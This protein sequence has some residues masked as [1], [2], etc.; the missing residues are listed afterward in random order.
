VTTDATQQRELEP[1][2][3]PT[4]LRTWLRSSP[5]RPVA[6]A[7]GVLLLGQLVVRGLLA[8]RGSF[9]VDDLAFTGRAANL[10][11]LSRD[12][13]LH[14]YNSHLMPGAFVWV[15]LLTHAWPLQFGPVATVDIALQLLVGIVFYRLL[16]ELFGTR[17]A[18]LVPFAIYLWSPIT[19]PAF[20][21]WAAALNQLPQQLA[22]CLALLYHAR[23]LRFGRVRT[24]VLG[25]VAVAG[26]LLFSEKT[27]LVVPLIVL[28]TALYFCRGGPWRRIVDTWRS[29]VRV[30]IAYLIVVVPYA[31]YYVMEVPSPARSGGTGGDMMHLVGSSYGHAVFP[32]LL[33]GPWRWSLIGFAGGLAHPTKIATYLSALTVLVIVVGSCVFIRGAILGWSLAVVYSALNLTLL[34]ASR[35]TMVGPIIGDEFRYVTDVALVA[36]L[37]GALAVLPLAGQWH[38]RTPFRPTLRLHAAEG[39]ARVS[40]P[41]LREVLPVRRL[42]W[43]SALLACAFVI[44]ALI[45]TVKYDKY[46][47][48]NPTRPYL[49]HL[50]HDLSALPHGAVMYDGVVPN[51]VAWA[52]LAPYNRYSLLLKPLPNEPAFLEPGASTP[53]L[54]T[55]DTQGY[56][57]L[58]GVEGIQITKGPVR[59]CGWLLGRKATS[60]PLQQRTF[61]WT[62]VLRMGYIASADTSVRI[63]TGDTTVTV[64]IQSGLHAAY[65]LVTGAVDTVSVSGTTGAATICTNDI[66]VGTPVPLPGTG[67]S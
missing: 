40:W 19:L 6:A 43:L 17:P 56:V 8:Y 28:F 53:T 20:L 31:T 10:P 33:G 9:F 66:V 50:R 51:E 18:I 58:A 30:W 54:Y 13:L 36:A 3:A 67:P 2:A 45:S 48:S 34:A 16:R 52:L 59:N 22:M 21:W 25:A 23:Y 47:R 55:I 32:G 60:I 65:V 4:P 49:A 64:P 62:W 44:S 61:P 15:W 14:A 12:Y 57:R 5:G 42:G 7:A 63:R 37:G 35:A 27:L 26:G 11:L 29:H 1:G 39:L 41:D 38:A 46:W 24:G